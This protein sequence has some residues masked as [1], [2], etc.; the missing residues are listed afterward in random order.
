MFLVDL[1]QLCRQRGAPLHAEEGV[2]PGR[3]LR[4]AAEVDART[5][6]LWELMRSLGPT[7]EGEKEGRM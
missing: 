3:E 7:K 4:R 6:G 2:D 5:E 1:V